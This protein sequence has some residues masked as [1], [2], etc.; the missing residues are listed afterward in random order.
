MSKESTRSLP[1][2]FLPGADPSEP[3]D[4]PKEEQEKLHKVLRLPQGAPIAVLPNNGSLIRCEYRARQAVPVGV[5]WPDTEPKLQLTIAQALPKGDRLDTVIRMCTEL[6]VT[7]FILFPADRSVVI[8]EKSKFEAK[9]R[10]YEAIARESAEQSFRCRLPEISTVASL[11][12]LLESDPSAVV[13]SEVEGIAGRLA[14]TGDK[15]TVAVGPEGGWSP[16]ELALIVD[17]GVSLGSL[18][19]RTDTAGVAAAAKLLI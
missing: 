1:R 16:K 3:I 5:E 15:M 17:R 14:V 2:I 11:A 10:R 8:W 6:G 19:L 7:R 9:L 13:L 4:L 18:V 12:A